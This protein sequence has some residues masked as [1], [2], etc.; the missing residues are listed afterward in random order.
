MN[1]FLILTKLNLREYF[2]MPKDKQARKRK[3]ATTIGLSVCFL[4]IIVLMCVG[5]YFM[6]GNIA[7]AGGLV[8]LIGTIIFM[9][10]MIVIFFGMASYLSVM[11][12][13]KDN[14]FLAHLPV[15][16]MTVYLSK[17]LVVYLTNLIVSLA[18][19]LPTTITAGAAAT[20][21]GYA[22]GAHY[23]ILAVFGSLF[24]PILPLLLIAILSVPIAYIAKL[25]K[26]SSIATTII[27]LSLFVGVYIGYMVM[28][29]NITG[30]MSDSNMDAMI[31]NIVNMLNTI[32]KVFY[33]NIFIASAMTS[34]GLDAFLNSLYYLLVVIGVA[35][36]AL[37]LSKFTYSKCSSKFREVSYSNKVVVKA[38]K[39]SSQ[40]K[41]LIIRDIKSIMREPGL[42][43]NCFM[44]V[45]MAPLL[46]GIFGTFGASGIA[47]SGAGMQSSMMLLMAMTMLTGTNYL[48][49]IAVSREGEKFYIIKYLPVATD[50]YIKSKV[51]LADIYICIGTVLV[52][53]VALAVGVNVLAVV[54][55]AANL[56][57]LGLAINAISIK[58]DIK[59]P[60]L[61]WINSRKLMQSR[62]NILVMMLVSL[63]EGI[64]LMVMMTMLSTVIANEYVL[65]LVVYGVALLVNTVLAIIFR[66]DM[67]SSAE[68]LFNKIEAHNG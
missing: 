5:V 32:S 35:S 66:R 47:T 48:A 34:H 68:A 16:S 53:I 37:V 30:N 36:I 9:A 21:A 20:A 64:V 28:I 24:V 51:Y 1:K 11:Y 65:Y 50:T 67:K 39:R 40:I 42:A 23:Y 17:L 8:G 14:E 22:V 29:Y 31:P 19:V 57:A 12:F 46:A 41:A 43:M 56:M 45:I 6:A 60:N 38:A 3:L 4:P 55:M 62:S 58:K 49:N 33:P 25:F 52:A 27:S 59:R 54:F 61:H 13:S 10:Q 26:R 18:I 44:G 2:G 63:V 7:I 15:S